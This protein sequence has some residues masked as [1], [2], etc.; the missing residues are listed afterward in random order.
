MNI[1]ALTFLA[2]FLFTAL[3]F[4][5][6]QETPGDTLSQG[7]L[8]IGFGSLGFFRNN[9]FYSPVTR[10]YTLTGSH[11]RPLLLWSP[12]EG[13]LVKAGGFIS[14]WSGYPGS[15]VVRPVFSSTFTLADGITVTVGSLDGADAHGM[16][17]P[18]YDSEKL[19]T[20][21]Q[22]DGFRF[23]L[24]RGRI[25]SDTWV[26]WERFIFAGDRHREELTFGES[27]RYTAGR[28][29][30]RVKVEFPVQ[31]LAK[32]YGGDISIYNE[33]VETHI[34]L[35]GGARV[36]MSGEGHSNRS[37]GIEATGFMYGAGRDPS[38]IDFGK[39][40]ALWLRADHT[41]GDL[42]M[43]AGLWFSDNFHSPNGNPVYGSISDYRAGLVIPSRRIFSGSVNYS[44]QVQS[45]LV[46]FLQGLDW[47]YDIRDGRFD[48]TMTLHIR[49]SERPYW[50]SR[51]RQ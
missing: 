22:E 21:F 45:G 51:L 12:A 39:G 18:H 24:R 14:I 41:R 20:G 31:L 47:Y 48:Y 29:G 17:D 23:Q 35:A 9:E 30:S 1:R 11:L 33:P 37:T 43:T 27:F 15:P 8:G 13:V 2:T 6:G 16:F 34:N 4:S 32:H 46:T 28:D 38:D 44:K 36:V 49:I 42:F 5:A 3:P 10:G 7:R 19:Y 50:F 26:D 25:S 40:K